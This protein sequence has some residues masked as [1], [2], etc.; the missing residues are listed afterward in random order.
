M[1][2]PMRRL[3]LLA[4]TVIALTVTVAVCFWLRT[5]GSGLIRLSND[6]ILIDD[7]LAE[8]CYPFYWQ[9]AQ[10]QQL[11][12]ILQ[13][14]TR[15]PTGHDAM[16]LARYAE[17][18]LMKDDPQVFREGMR[19]DPHNALYHYLLAS[20]YL[21][22]AVIGDGPDSAYYQKTGKV[23]YDY[24]LKDR[25][26]LDLGMHEL[27][28]GMQLPY[29]THRQTLVHVRLAAMPPMTTLGSEMNGMSCLAGVR[30]PEFAKMRNLVRINGYYL[31]LLLAEAKRAQ[32]EPFLHTGERLSV[33][34]AQDKPPTLI[35]TLV[36]MAISQI[37]ENNDADVCRQYGFTQEAQ[38]IVTHNETLMGGAKRWKASLHQPNAQMDDLRQHY[39]GMIGAITFPEFGNFHGAGI[40][41]ETLR[42]SRLMDY[43]FVEMGVSCVLC[44]FFF[45][46]L[47]FAGVEYWRFSRLTRDATQARDA[48]LSRGEVVCVI[49]MGFV[50]P[51]ALYLLYIAIPALSGRE[52][53]IH[54]S[55]GQFIGGLSVAVLWMLLVPTTMAAGKVWQRRVATGTTP[56]PSRRKIR[57]TRLC[58]SLGVMAWAIV[59][60]LTVLFPI[61]LLLLKTVAIVP[62]LPVYT[63][64]VTDIVVAIVMF[65][66]VAA[67]PFIPML[68]QRKLAANAS[69]YRALARTMVTVY[70]AMTVLTGLLVPVCGAYERHF[71]ATDRVTGLV[72]ERDNIAFTYAEGK[73]VLSLRD[74]I[75]AGAVKLGIPWQ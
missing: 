46:L 33:Q 55:L 32:A 50:A 6:T 31:S 66:I 40:T 4:A 63:D 10:R 65:V 61:G 34:L 11:Q 72:H 71:V 25:R 18:A 8:R 69:H 48:S 64:I 67:S 38:H 54:T 41:R 37:C 22:R 19:R 42:P 59:A 16:G 17:Y 74:S 28:V 75:H 21:N 62:P 44:M 70:A 35:G 52:K 29:T 49:L 27:V 2:L 56:C 47:L 60:V 3:L 7:S 30:F 12:T 45:T 5:V 58:S 57:C 53:N 36:A 14:T 9:D 26:L 15:P 43:V 39:T 24:T 13:Q 68:W 73:L 23:R 51:L 20:Y 1:G